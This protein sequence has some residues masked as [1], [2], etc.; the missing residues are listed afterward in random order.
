VTR[1]EKGIGGARHYRFAG[2]THTGT[3]SGAALTNDLRETRSFSRYRDFVVTGC[4][5][6][7]GTVRMFVA[8]IATRNTCSWRSRLFSKEIHNGIRP[9]DR[10]S[11]H[12]VAGVAA[13][14]SSLLSARCARQ[15]EPAVR[16]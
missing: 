1:A 13:V 2:D 5:L 3:G 9:F 12:A 14:F 16:A 10:D 8:E 7:E 15:L 4:A 6:D 11:D